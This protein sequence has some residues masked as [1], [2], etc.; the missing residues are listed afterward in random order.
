MKLPRICALPPIYDRSKDLLGV[1]GSRPVLPCY[2]E[3]RAG[4][5]HLQLSIE[6]VRI[7][8]EDDNFEERS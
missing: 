2:F 6:E 3:V 1:M 5:K 7:L 8:L 4:S